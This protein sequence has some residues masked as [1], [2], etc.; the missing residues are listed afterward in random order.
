M[1]RAVQFDQ[2]G[3]VEVLQVRD[4]ARPVAGP[5]RVLIEVRAAGINPGEAMIREG[6]LHDRWPA[7]FPSGQGSDVAGVV[8]EVAPDV[9]G[10]AVGDEV[11]GFSDERSTQAE[12][13]ALPADQ[14]TPKP[15]ELSWEQAGSLNVAGTTA[16]AAVRSLGLTADDTVAVSA[17]A[18]GVGT[19]AVQLAVRTGATV[20]GIAGP[21]ND[22]W[23][24]DHGVIPVNYG[25]GLAER[26][27][28][29]APGGRVDAFL[30]LFGGGYVALA[31]EELGVAPQRVDTII[32]FAAVEQFGV[33]SVGSAEAPGTTAL[34]ELADLIARGELDLPIAAVYPLDEVRAAYTD[35]A[36]RHSRGKVVLRP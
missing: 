18:G 32:D 30:D 36:A 31:V 26:L 2:Y 14:V 8:V 7:T 1:S 16:Y 21:A 9:T 25:D 11:L 3:G 6:F 4:V 12:Y 29:A 22:D 28:A 24:R 15:A 5:G 10:V 33:Q 17:A 13:V 34:A 19:L 20:L 35:L 23:L 27:R